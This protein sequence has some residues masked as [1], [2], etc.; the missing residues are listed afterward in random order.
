MRRPVAAAVAL[1][2]LATACSGSAARQ[3]RDNAVRGVT[4]DEITVAFHWNKDGCGAD[5]AERVTSFGTKPDSAVSALVEFVNA[6][7][8]DGTTFDGVPIRLHGRRIRPVFVSSG[9]PDPACAA[10]NRAAGIEIADEVGAFAAVS[11]TLSFDDDQVA[12]VVA[13]KGVLHLGASFLS[14]PQ[15][16]A[17]HDPYVWS[18]FPTGTAMVTH[19]ADYL[20]LRLAKGGPPGHTRYDGRR[21]YGLVRADTPAARVVADELVTALRG[22]V[23]IT[24][25]VTYR[26]DFA[27]AQQQ[28]N[29]AVARFKADGVNTLILLTDPVAPVVLTQ[30][31]QQQG[32]SPDY[33]ISSYGYLDTPE[34]AQNYPVDQWRH[35][36]GIS[37]FGPEVQRR[38]EANRER[39]Y[40]RA[41]TEVRPGQT[42]PDDTVAWYATMA[43]LVWAISGAGRE[44]TA[45]S[46]AA[47]LREV[48]ATRPGQPPVDYLPGRHGA[49][50]SYA[51]VSFEPATTA[52]RFVEGARRYSTTT[53]P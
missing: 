21:V 38:G 10:Q 28:A 31:A 15:F 45:G 22:E 39:P 16:Y 1:A 30:V 20:R 3:G 43:P 17:R 7:D 51:L 12:P 8:G 9:G 35:A 49:T 27:A 2:L 4:D 41:F 5:V 47:A 33:V 24:T 48:R 29:A 14:E 26:A 6:H 13:E 37:E 36:F 18:P 44:L 46:A 53:P 23:R 40:H 32:W 52:Y 42:P 34:A 25:T 19:L 11:S 50:D